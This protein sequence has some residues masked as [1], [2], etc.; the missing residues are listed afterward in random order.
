MATKSGGLA[1][2]I[3]LLAV[4]AGAGGAALF[5]YSRP[6]AP[7]QVVKEKSVLG[8]GLEDATKAFGVEPTP[9]AKM[10]GENAPGDDYLY[11]IKRSG[12]Q[13]LRVIVRV[14]SSG[15]INRVAAVDENM[16]EIELP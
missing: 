11:I 6:P 4:L 1:R 2:L 15:K 5:V 14:A 13:D 7:E 10:A 16:V 9:V 3:V 8:M 12:K